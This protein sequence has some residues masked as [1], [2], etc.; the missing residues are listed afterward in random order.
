MINEELLKAREIQIN[1]LP[2]KRLM[3][4]LLPIESKAEEM[5]RRWF[6]EL[7]QN[8]SD[9][10]ESVD[11][12]LHI[13]DTQIVFKHN[14][15]PF[16]SA[17]VLNLISPDSNKD[18]VKIQTDNIGKF[19]SGLITTH[20]LSS[21]LTVEGA[22][23]SKEGSNFKFMVA[24][25][26]SD[27]IDKETIINSQ[28][29]SI[30]ELLNQEKKSFNYQQGEFVNCFTYDL[31]RPFGSIDSKSYV[32]ASINYI[33]EML[34][35]T[36]AFMEKVQ[37]ISIYNTSKLISKF[38]SFSIKQATEKDGVLS[39][40]CEKNGKHETIKVLKLTSKR[41]STVVILENESKIK[42]FPEK[43]TKLFCGL[44]LV[45]TEK[46]G[47]PL[48][49]NSLNFKPT[50]EREG[51]NLS[52]NDKE[53]RELMQES[54]DLFELLLKELVKRKCENIYE[55]LNI[56]T[57]F[58]GNEA[59]QIWFKQT[60]IKE[61]RLKAE[62]HPIILNCEGEFID[63]IKV[64]IPSNTQQEKFY[65]LTSVFNPSAIPSKNSFKQ[66]A[67][68]LNFDLFPTIKYSLHHFLE[69]LT[70]TKFINGFAL[71]N[72]NNATQWLKE[73]IE[74]VEKQDNNLFNKYALLPNR[75]NELKLKDDELYFGIDLPEDLIEIN[76]EL[77]SEIYQKLLLH[78]DFEAFGHILGHT[79][80]IRVKNLCLRIDN[81][82]KEKYSAVKG[83][84]LLF[85]DPLRKLLK[86]YNTTKIG[87]ETLKEYMPWFS[88]KRAILFLDTFN[89]NE[90]D[91]ALLI[92]QSGKMNALAELA[93]SHISE[94]QIRLLLNKSV[95]LEKVLAMLQNE[96]L[97]VVT[98]IDDK[99]QINEQTGIKGEEIVY[100]DLRKK[101]PEYSG[102]KVIWASKE[103]EAKYD[104]EVKKGNETI[105]YIEVKATS[106]SLSNSDNIPFFVRKAQW[107]F[108][109]SEQ[110]NGKYL[111]ARVFSTNS[112]HE[113]K[114]VT[115]Y[116]TKLI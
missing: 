18:D 47:M 7:L 36:L 86:W 41:T 32:A 64:K 61:I 108:I 2:A 8:A 40:E 19:G 76:N 110:A 96:G 70:K 109:D 94:E 29:N 102:Y 84:T 34:P 83:D 69:S 25:D 100:A 51:V 98:V 43:M 13:S 4:K 28:Q 39:F 81:A 87:K 71:H 17:D 50:I 107:Q 74:F 35:Y 3:E 20:F 10:N 68:I 115:F 105:K 27:Y 62:K 14:G 44:P 55:V 97:D 16:S 106:T 37:S 42:P 24:L 15:V 89:D 101:F 5:S 79:K 85:I 52:P 103:G 65:D 6:W 67:K 49:V 9:Y 91:A 1:S 63:L 58:E 11:V 90:R 22:L 75:E 72:N 33:L 23:K 104:F 113:V 80:E 21:I 112:A 12:Q 30:K 31:N 88:R 53:N 56:Q 26:R 60:Y 82:I 111:V 73:V 54:I 48:I 46:T 66:W 77:S 38:K 59:S 116:K 78:T 92:A 99:T 95:S 45:G 57:V 93:N 114:Y